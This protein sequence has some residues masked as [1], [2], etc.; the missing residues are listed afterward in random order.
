MG[1]FISSKNWTLVQFLMRPIFE[2]E[3]F[4]GTEYAWTDSSTSMTVIHWLLRH[5]L[6]Y[7]HT[8]LGPKTSRSSANLSA[9]RRRDKE[10]LHWR[11]RESL[12]WSRIFGAVENLC[13]SQESLSQSR[14]CS[15]PAVLIN[16]DEEEDKGWMMRWKK[17]FM[18][19]IWSHHAWAGLSPFQNCPVNLLAYC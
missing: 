1:W 3:Q 14:I 11:D 17:W 4:P 10:S 13:P 12:T 8:T 2:I 19:L 15:V 16:M 5:G 6:T 7:G 18:N 9:N